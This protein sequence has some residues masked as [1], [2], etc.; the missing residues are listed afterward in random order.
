MPPDAPPSTPA[1]PWASAWW[2]WPTVLSLDAPVVAVLWQWE[3]ARSAGVDL[4]APRPFV[5]GASVWLAYAADRWIE[6]CRLEPGRIQT[7]RHAFYHHWRLPVAWAWA[8][9]LAA[10]VGAALAGLGRGE[11]TL[12]LVLLAAVAAY[13]FSHQLLH[14]HHR[15]RVPKEACVGLLLAGGAVLFPAAAPAARPGALATPALLFATLGFANC[16]L[17]STWERQVDRSH[18][19]GSLALEFGA[20]ARVAR[21]LPWAIGGLALMALAGGGTVPGPRTADAGARAPVL[22][23]AAASGLLLGA[24]DLL[25]PRLGRRLARVLADLALM[26]PAAH[27]LAVACAFGPGG[28]GWRS[29]GL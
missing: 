6:G 1:A 5:L 28:W 13:L 16:A 7:E 20:G 22:A 19:Q 8:A 29:S 18:G 9:I 15:L 4:R 25:E 12:G 26:T 27:L 2:Q 21:V 24:V 11:I 14:R 10:D 23:C 3:I 17:I